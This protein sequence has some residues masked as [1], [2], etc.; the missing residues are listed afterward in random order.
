MN[1]KSTRIRILKRLT[2]TIINSKLKSQ[3]QIKR[4]ISKKIDQ[5][6]EKICLIFSGKILK[7]HETLTQHKIGDGYLLFLKHANIVF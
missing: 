4:Q 6:E 7:D 2:I 3:F 1:L 5:P